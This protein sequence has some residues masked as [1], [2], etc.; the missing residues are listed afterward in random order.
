VNGLGLYPAVN[1]LAFLLCVV[2]L[3][4]VGLI[5][6][7]YLQSRA[8]T[9]GDGG[10][11]RWHLLMPCLDEEVVVRRTIE[12]ALRDLPGVH[13]WCIDDA[14]SDGTLSI[15]DAVAA[16]RPEVHV[17]PRT[18]PAAQQGKGAALNAGWQAVNDWVTANEIDPEHVIVGVIDADGRLDPRCFDVLAGPAFFGAPEVGAVQLAVRIDNRTRGSLPSPTNPLRRLL[19]DLQ[20][21]EFMGPIAG[22]QLVRRHTASVSMGGNG[23]F[24]RLVVL[25]EVATWAGTPWHGSLL[26]DFELGLH[27]LMAGHRTAYCHHAAVHQEGL[28]SVRLLVRQRSRWAQGSM[29]CAQYLRPVMASTKIGHV[30]ALEICYFLVLP[31]IQLVGTVVYVL[32]YLI[33]GWYLLAVGVSPGTWVDSGQWG[34]LPLV[35]LGGIGPFFIWGPLYRSWVDPAVT[36]RRAFVLGVASWLYSNLHFAATWW[37]FLRV[38]ADRDDWKKSQR[39]VLGDGEQFPVGAP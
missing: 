4:Y 22:M 28:S 14:S 10:A 35:I 26:E 7:S 1:T 32:A 2:F 8:T 24:T 33:L 25:N 13:L 34:V 6:V 5:I 15:L 12:R 21:V 18:F 39:A 38:L 16:V 20:D 3:A 17:I 31:W 11:F 9:S 30:G 27:V 29:Q 19:V 37:A 23:Q 36:R